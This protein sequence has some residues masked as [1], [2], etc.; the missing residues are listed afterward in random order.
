MW[1]RHR[2]RRSKTFWFNT[3]EVCWCPILVGAR[4]RNSAD[5]VHVLV[6]RNPIVKQSF[7]CVCQPISSTTTQVDFFFVL[8]WLKKRLLCQE[9]RQ[10]DRHTVCGVHLPYSSTVHH[11]IG[12]GVSSWCRWADPPPPPG[13]CSHRT[14]GPCGVTGRHRHTHFRIASQKR[15]RRKKSPVYVV[16][17]TLTKVTFVFLLFSLFATSSRLRTASEELCQHSHS[18]LEEDDNTGGGTRLHLITSS[19]ILDRKMDSLEQR[20][21]WHCLYRL[22][23]VFRFQWVAHKNPS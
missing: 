4:Q 11:C 23:F 12:F 13:Y 7:L 1:T 15:R 10:D 6:T 19:R 9:N 5:L 3:T 17:S 8:M 22:V 18:W 16:V 14:Y 20:T 2:R 21:K